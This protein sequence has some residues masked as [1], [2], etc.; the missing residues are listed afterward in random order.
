M[1]Y[2]EAI[3]RVVDAAIAWWSQHTYERD[4]KTALQLLCTEP[5]QPD[6]MTDHERAVLRAWL[7][8]QVGARQ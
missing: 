3:K 1:T 8:P 6:L 7:R 2:D 5:S 4:L